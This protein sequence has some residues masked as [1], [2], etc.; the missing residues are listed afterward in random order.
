M[1]STQ[2][3]ISFSS[4]HQIKQPK[5]PVYQSIRKSNYPNLQLSR[6]IWITNYPD[7]LCLHRSKV[8]HGCLILLASNCFCQT[9]L[10]SGYLTSQKGFN[11]EVSGYPTIQISHLYPVLIV[12]HGC[13]MLLAT[14][15]CVKFIQY[16]DTWLAKKA[17]I[18]RY[19][20]IQVS[21]H[22]TIRTS[23]LYPA[24]I[25]IHGCSMLLATSRLFV[26]NSNRQEM[27]HLSE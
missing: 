24:L 5:I 3:Y 1:I 4:R 18:L 26:S 25:V 7:I 12:I 23:H 13:S 21:G 8:I 10:V 2:L 16:P 17:S 15:F 11:F 6:S 22:P 20:Y 9:Y 19:P 27:A 14:H